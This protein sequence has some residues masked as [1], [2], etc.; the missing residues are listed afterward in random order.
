MPEVLAALFTERLGRV[1]TIEDLGFGRRGRVG[2]RRDS[3]TDD[4]PDRLPWAPERTAAVLTEFTGMDLMLN[5]R[6]FGE[7][8]RRA[9]R[10]I[11]HRRPHVRMASQRPRSGGRSTTRQHART[12]RS[13]RFRPVRGGAGRLR[14]D[15]G[16]GVLRRGVPSLG[17]LPGRRAAAMQG[18]RG[19]AQRGGRHAGLPPPRSSPAPPV[20][21]RR[22]PRRPRG[23]DAP[24]TSASNPPPRSTS[25]SPPTRRAREATGRAPERRSPARHA[26]WCTWAGR[27]TRWT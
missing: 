5:R 20:G 17:R 10:R 22:Q 21:R 16:P 19:P 12:R 18:R 6:G 3:G 1:V 27:T 15:R 2:K 24:T 11:N 7:C 14:G 4:D 26:R 9:H 25:S 8:G 23:L 13:R